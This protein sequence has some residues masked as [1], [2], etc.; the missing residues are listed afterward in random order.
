[1][2]HVY[3]VDTKMVDR[4]RQY[5]MSR[6]DG[7][8]GFQR[9]PAAIDSFGRAPNNITNAYI[10]W[11]LTE[12]GKDDDIEKELT[13]LAG[14]AKDS[15]DPYFIALVANSLINRNQLDQGV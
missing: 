9:N 11:A 6:K 15:K 7:K 10:V 4:T 3:D 12:S 14:Q 1:M 8:G 2:A 5:L 13:A